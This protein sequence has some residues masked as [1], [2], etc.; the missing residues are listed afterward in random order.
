M[1]LISDSEASVLVWPKGD[2][3]VREDSIN[4]PPAAS[5]KGT[6]IKAGSTWQHRTSAGKGLFVRSASSEAVSVE[7]MLLDSAPPKKLPKALGVVAGKKM[8]GRS[9]KRRF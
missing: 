8:S 1:L 3:M 4:E 2:I 7:Y 9:F 6:T 5:A